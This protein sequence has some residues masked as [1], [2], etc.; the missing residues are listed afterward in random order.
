M[1]FWNGVCFPFKNEMF[2]L[3]QRKGIAQAI[4]EIKEWVTK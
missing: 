4:A 2:S 1:K 3:M